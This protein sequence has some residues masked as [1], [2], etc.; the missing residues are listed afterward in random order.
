MSKP[1]YA[2]RIWDKDGNQKFLD[3]DD[4][5]SLPRLEVGDQ[6]VAASYD[7]KAE[8]HLRDTVTDAS[9]VFTLEAGNPKVI[10]SVHV[11]KGY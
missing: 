11:E 5:E 4:L 8:S 10:L 7:I 2:L 1:K 6:I 3:W 9:Y